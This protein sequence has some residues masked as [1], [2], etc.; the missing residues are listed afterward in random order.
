MD[1]RVGGGHILARRRD[2]NLRAFTLSVARCPHTH[3]NTVGGQ[4]SEAPA[5]G[6]GSDSGSGSGGGC[7]NGSACASA[8]AS[9]S[10]SERRIS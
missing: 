6:S 3:A 4:V 5:S 10:A 8:S 7:G 9:A 2:V 1:A